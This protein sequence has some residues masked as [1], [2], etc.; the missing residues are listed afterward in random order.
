MPKFQA[1]SP[2]SNPALL[3][4][5]EKGGSKMTKYEIISLAISLALLILSLLSYLKM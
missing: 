5:I 1:A 4:I 2:H 3:E